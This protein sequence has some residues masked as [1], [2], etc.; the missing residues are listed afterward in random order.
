MQYS[1]HIEPNDEKVSVGNTNIWEIVWWKTPK[2]SR[3]KLNTAQWVKRAWVLHLVQ[4]YRTQTDKNAVF[5][6]THWGMKDVYCSGFIY[7]GVIK[8]D[9]EKFE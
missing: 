1:C 8:S 9:L 5:V 6:G 7:S 2:G 3:K 4:Q